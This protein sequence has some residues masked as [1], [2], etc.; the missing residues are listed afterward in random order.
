MS[1]EVFALPFQAHANYGT[2]PI[3]FG[4]DEYSQINQNFIKIKF[5]L[6]EFKN[7]TK[8]YFPGS[9][10][11]RVWTVLLRSPTEINL[12]FPNMELEDKQ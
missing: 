3:D 7:K 1:C 6:K 8:K 9:P 4:V 11:I 2:W 12:L 10:L 5:Y